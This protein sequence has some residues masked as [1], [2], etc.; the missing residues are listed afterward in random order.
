MF[1]EKK[2]KNWSDSYWN[3]ITRNIG[4]ITLK[5]QNLL[6]HTGTIIFGVGGLGG[7]IAEQLVRTGF[8]RLIICDNDIFNESNL[9]RQLCTLKDLGKY[10]VDVIEKLLKNINPNIIV[11][12]YYEINERNISRILK[13]TSIAVLTLDDFI[14]SILIARKCSKLQIPLLESWGIPYLWAWWFTSQSI[15]YET[16][17]EYSTNDL[18]I[19]EIKH[20]EA[21][22]LK[23]K[24]QLFK[25]IT[26]FPDIM[27]IYDREK[28]ALEGMATGK[29]PFVSI[30]PVVRLTASYL[31]YE[32]IF[33]GVLKI[34]RKVLA[35]YIIGYDYYHMR[36]IDFKL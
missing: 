2:L 27:Q 20:S 31:T 8:E 13:D 28:G 24:Q 4:I 12:K 26:Q 34:K 33:S 3:H 35:P 25:K 1:K 6:K 36:P 7:S 29:L 21:M 23:F 30:A 16:C 9:N 11:Q 19:D 32:I 14:T 15:D 10:K 5:E 17:Y 18:S 22:E